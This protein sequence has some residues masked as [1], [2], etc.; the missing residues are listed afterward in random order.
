MNI[1]IVGAGLSGA[2]TAR[3]LA[4]AGHSLTVID[5]RD[6]IA[7]NCHTLR[8]PATDVMVHIHG[9]HIFHTDDPEV[10]AFVT[11]FA[12]MMPYH[13]RVKATVGGRVYSLPINLHTINQFFG[14]ALSP[15]QAQAFLADRAIPLAEGT[16]ANFETRALSL[17]GEDLYRAF[18]AGYTQ[19]QW[20]VEPAA[21]PASIISR[22]P[23][24][25]NYDDSYFFH[26]H[27]AIPRDGYTAMVAGILDHPAITLHLGQRAEAM[28]QTGAY[29]HVVYSGKLDRY[30]KDLF[31]P[32]GYRTL[33][34][35][36]ID[37]DGDYQGIAV[38]NYCDP[39][40]PFTRITEHKHF[41]PWEGR[42]AGK[43]VAFREYSRESGPTD[44]PYYPLR[45]AADQDRL[46]RYV[47]H[48]RQDSGVTFV[49]RLGTYSYLDMDVAI[50][51]AID[52]AAALTAA[53]GR[54]EPPPVFVH[55]PLGSG[56]K[57]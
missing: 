26:S 44:I 24:R 33:D 42:S 48:A 21:L 3:H 27:Q 53:W 23:F 1:L 41:A 8:D 43:S 56:G 18:F 15:A 10:W 13:H 37:H 20:G 7:G 11:R 45:L 12:E 47:D 2:V 31:G 5:E 29:D 32:L 49:G 35:E 55:D 34:F 28:P 16:P 14:T 4:E 6:H 52:T 17:M 30:Y 38:M 25:L 46:R 36:R 50:R 22:L 57:A 39:D 9:P 54:G 40:V 51:R 19:K